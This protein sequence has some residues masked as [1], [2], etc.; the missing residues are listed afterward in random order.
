MYNFELLTAKNAIAAATVSRMSKETR[1][2]NILVF[3]SCVRACS[4][5]GMIARSMFMSSYFDPVTVKLIIT[6]ATPH[7]PVILIDKD[8]KNFYWSVDT[9]WQIEKS[10]THSR[11]E[12]LTMISIGGGSRDILVRPG[13]TYNKLA[14]LNVLVRNIHNTLTISMS[15]HYP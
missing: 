10:K 8:L 12:N 1:R 13:L 15:I 4:Q 14:D 5:G 11:L 6:L 2:Q 3:D 9:F 7:Q